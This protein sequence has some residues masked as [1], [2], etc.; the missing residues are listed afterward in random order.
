VIK[1]LAK[2]I[3]KHS[4]TRRSIRFHRGIC[5]ALIAC[6][7]LAAFYLAR[8]LTRRREMAVRLALEQRKAAWHAAFV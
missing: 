2:E 5:I 7:N 6:S 3:G 8:A 1:H 4:A